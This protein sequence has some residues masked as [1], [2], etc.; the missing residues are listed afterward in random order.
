MEKLT[1]KYQL[2]VVVEPTFETF[3]WDKFPEEPKLLHH[4]KVTTGFYHLSVGST[5]GPNEYRPFGRECCP[6][7]NRGSVV[8]RDC[9]GDFSTTCIPCSPG[10]FM[11]EPNGL[12]QCFPCRQCA[13]SQGLYIQSKCTAVRDTI[14]DVLDGYRC[15][16]FSNSECLHA[17]KHRVCKPGQETKTPGTKASDTECV[18]CAS[19]FYSPSGLSCTKWTDCA[20]R[21][22]IQAEDGSPVK[23]VTCEQKPK[24]IYGLVD[25][26]AAS[27][28][29]FYRS[30][31]FEVQKANN[32]EKK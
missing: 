16:R 29:E 22:E 31:F 5:C 24:E 9:T 17:E 23:D 30:L 8:Y 26:I 10:T 11:S 6:M 19:G 27:L 20:A 3:Q 14:C 2:A 18:D 1:K 25:L 15:V 21:N 32:E 4:V 28:A 7:C 12:Y 13:E